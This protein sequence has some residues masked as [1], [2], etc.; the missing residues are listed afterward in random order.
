MRIDLNAE[1]IEIL[2]DGLILSRDTNTAP[3]IY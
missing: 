1:Q 3:L 2:L